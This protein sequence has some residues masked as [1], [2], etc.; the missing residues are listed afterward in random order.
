MENKIYN[1][2][3]DNQDDI[4]N[5]FSEYVS[6][7]EWGSGEDRID[8]DSLFDEYVEDLYYAEEELS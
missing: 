2:Y 1:W 8:T 6:F 3:L 4:E 7:G 5:S